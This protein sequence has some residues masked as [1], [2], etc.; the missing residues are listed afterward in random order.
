[1]LRNLFVGYEAL[2]H[3]IALKCHKSSNHELHDVHRYSS[4][5][6]IYRSNKSNFQN[7]HGRNSLYSAEQRNYLFLKIE[8]AIKLLIEI[9]MYKN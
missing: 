3:S 7:L 8:Y 5:S 2:C 1:M 6:Y 9:L 4:G